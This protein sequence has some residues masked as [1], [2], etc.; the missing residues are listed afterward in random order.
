MIL[1]VTFSNS[2]E[3]EPHPPLSKKGL[4][5]RI[6]GL[7]ATIIVILNWTIEQCASICQ[8]THWGTLL[9]ECIGGLQN[10]WNGKFWT[11]L[12]MMVGSSV[13]HMKLQALLLSLKIVCYNVDRMGS[14]HRKK[15]RV[16]EYKVYRLRTWNNKES[17]FVVYT[18][19]NSTELVIKFQV[20][21]MENK[22]I[23]ENIKHF[24]WGGRNSGCENVRSL[25]EGQGINV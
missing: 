10:W 21:V 8:I 1:L 23:E 17:G 12:G 4:I 22:G 16:T 6:Q 2:N 3:Q 9:H 18:E 15:K 11:E 13:D 20:K 24:S 14:K 7:R 25:H 5:R 19:L